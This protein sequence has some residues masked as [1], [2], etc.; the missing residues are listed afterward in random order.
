MEGELEGGLAFYW[1]G[2]TKNLEAELASYD[3]T[4]LTEQA[5]GGEGL[6]MEPSDT[7]QM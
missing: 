5:T 6:S 1:R 4:Q 7:E 3:A 2:G